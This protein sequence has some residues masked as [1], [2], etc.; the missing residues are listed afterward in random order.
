MTAQQAADGNIILEK[1]HSVK[2]KMFEVKEL[3]TIPAW[4]VGSKLKI[5]DTFFTQIVFSLK[6]K[7]KLWTHFLGNGMDYYF[8]EI[9][10]PINLKPE[11][12]PF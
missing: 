12:A 1:K 4:I 10:L 9:D 6:L 2:A 8:M 5:E 11:T 3:T 7:Q